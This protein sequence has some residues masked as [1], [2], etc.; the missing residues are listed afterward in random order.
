MTSPGLAC[1][2]IAAATALACVRWVV[3]FCADE[4]SPATAASPTTMTRAF[5]LS[6]VIV[7]VPTSKRKGRNTTAA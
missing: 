6:S 7:P 4:T 3:T 5:G 2:L 1:A